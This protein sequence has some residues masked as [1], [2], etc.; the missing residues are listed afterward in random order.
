MT[1]HQC[2]LCILLRMKPIPIF[3]SYFKLRLQLSYDC[4]YNFLLPNI[5][6]I[7]LCKGIISDVIVQLDENFD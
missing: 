2:D 5:C 3:V 6:S 4:A 7:T 1:L